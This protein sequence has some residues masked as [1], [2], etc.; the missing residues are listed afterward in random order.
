M[1]AGRLA[2]NTTFLQHTLDWT[3]DGPNKSDYICA[4][5]SDRSI[6]LRHLPRTQH[7]Q[8]L[9]LCPNW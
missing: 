1:I 6:R 8:A 2:L 7:N 3:S 4:Y 5:F 9:G